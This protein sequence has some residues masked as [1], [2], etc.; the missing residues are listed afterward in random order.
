[1]TYYNEYYEMLV[2]ISDDGAA[3][4]VVTQPEELNGFRFKIVN[5]KLE[6]EFEGIKFDVNNDQK[7]S[8]VNFLLLPFKEQNPSVYKNDNQFFMKGKCDG[9]EYIMYITESG[10]PLKIFDSSKRFE[11][12]IKNLKVKKEKEP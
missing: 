2:D 6:C 10:L 3:E 7:A 5:D 9:G 8:A 11:I 4:I 12:T 1:M